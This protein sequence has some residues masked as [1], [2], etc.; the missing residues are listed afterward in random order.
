MSWQDQFHQDP[1]PWLLE[2]QD[3]GV[4]YLALRDLLA[5]DPADSELIQ[6][7]ALAHQNGPIAAVLDAMSEPGYWAEPGPGYLPK[8]RSTVWSIILLGQLGASIHLDARIEQACHYLLDHTLTEFGQFSG[9]GSP[10]GTVDCLQGNL[11]GALL[12]LG[13]EDPRLEQ[14]WDW[15]ARTVT[16]E[17]VAPMG[18]KDTPIRYYAGKIGPN[19]ACG[20]NNKLPCAWGAV[21][22]MLAFSKLPVKQRTPLIDA[23]IQQS[24]EFLLGVDPLE[25]AY[26]TGYAEKP[27]GNWWKFGF[28]VFYVT[29]LLQNME[30]LVRLGMGEDPRL[31]GALAYIREKQ[32]SDGRWR[33]EYEYS[34]KT[35]FEFGQK[36]QP[37]KWVTYRTAYV[38]KQ[39]AY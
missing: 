15:M 38:L 14:A 33:L 4:R 24:V 25:A 2:K 29:D 31:A 36:K 27:S 16:G 22:V 18:A 12:D 7:Q 19:F 21:K 23:A 11:L 34:G 6:A 3:P 26:P 5:L 20:A 39:T 9:S 8:Y 35:W 32:D 10:G 1:L 28:P 30:A 17:G 13:F 37:N